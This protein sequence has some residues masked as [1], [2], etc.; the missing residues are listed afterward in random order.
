MESAA[1]KVENHFSLV[2][3][4]GNDHWFP[5]ESEISWTGPEATRNLSKQCLSYRRI[6]SEQ[7][8]LQIHR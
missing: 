1:G 2:V 6:N 7:N 8:N 4:N 5:W 3:F